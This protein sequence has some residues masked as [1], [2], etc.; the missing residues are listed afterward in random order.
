[1]C[2]KPEKKTPDN[3]VRQLKR[4]YTVAISSPHSWHMKTSIVSSPAGMTTVPST[5]N[6]PRSFGFVHVD[7]PCEG[8]DVASRERCSDVQQQVSRMSVP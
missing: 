8:S 6:L 1:M 4:T 2:D 3:R 5:S 7:S